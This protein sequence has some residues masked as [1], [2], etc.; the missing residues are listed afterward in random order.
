MTLAPLLTAPLLVQLHAAAAISALGLG[1]WQIAAPKG[2][3]PHRRLG[4]IW[5]GLMAVVALSSFGITPH[6]FSWIH[7]IAVVTLVMLPL[8]VG[9]ARSGRIV[10]HRR[11]MLSLFFGALVVAGGFTLMP[12]RIMGRVVFGG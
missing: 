3:L 1:V 9:H 11:V 7:A 4:W 6:G 8:A 12:A 10:G 5:V 2:T